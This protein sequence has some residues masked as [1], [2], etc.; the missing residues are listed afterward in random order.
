MGAAITSTIAET[1]NI[2]INERFKLILYE[3]LIGLTITL[4]TQLYGKPNHNLN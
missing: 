3:S 1:T 4:V 2:S